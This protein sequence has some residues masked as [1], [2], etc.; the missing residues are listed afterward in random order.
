VDAGSI[1]APGPGAAIASGASRSG[2]RAMPAHPAASS[3]HSTPPTLATDIGTL[4][5]GAFGIAGA[6]FA[7]MRDVRE[8]RWR[9]AVA[10]PFEQSSRST[11]SR[12]RG[13]ALAPRTQSTPAP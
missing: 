8:R 2:A 13:G 6:W 11:A 12:A 3:M 4:S 5:A 9:G 10:E 7:V 1:E